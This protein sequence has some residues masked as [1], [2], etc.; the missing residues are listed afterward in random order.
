[1]TDDTNDLFTWFECDPDNN[2]RLIN[3]RVAPEDGVFLAHERLLLLQAMHGTDSV[4]Q[5]AR[6]NIVAIVR[7]WRRGRSLPRVEAPAL[8]AL[9]EHLG[10]PAPPCKSSE[11][12][13]SVKEAVALLKAAGY[14]G[15]KPRRRP[16]IERRV[17]PTFVATF[18]DGEVTRMSTFTLSTDLDV[19]RGVR[20]SEA[21]YCSRKRTEIVPPIA[22]AHFEQD[23][24]ALA[25]YST[26]PPEERQGGAP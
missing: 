22:K 26:F 17:G 2:A 23:G 20:L 6:L 10:P 3:E 5:A 14:R 4:A 7:A 12:T 25:H 9:F 24:K 11:S 19:R 21:A 16:R 18:H 15:S 13:V 8:M 1:M